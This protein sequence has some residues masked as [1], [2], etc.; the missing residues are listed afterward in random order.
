MACAAARVGSGGSVALLGRNGLRAKGAV[1][2]L[3]P[4][5]LRYFLRRTAIPQRSGE[6]VV[7]RA[8]PQ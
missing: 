7:L 5:S 4:Q 2:A 1:P 6:S 3:L 8:V